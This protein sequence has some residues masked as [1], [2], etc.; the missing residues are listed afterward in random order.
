MLTNHTHALY[1]QIKQDLILQIKEGKISIN[2]QLPT[3]LELMKQYNVSRITVSKALNE[4]KNEGIIIRYPGKGSFVSSCADIS[5]NT[6]S[7]ATDSIGL[8]E[9]ACLLPNIRDSFALSI[10]R[11]FQD[12]FPSS[13]YLCH[14]M[15]SCNSEKENQILQYCIDSGIDGLVLFPLDQ[16]F[17][18]NQL[19]SM[20]LH[21]YPFVFVDK[22]LSKLDTSY[23]ISDNHTGGEYCFK[24]LHE[25]GHKNIAFVS[26]SP[27]ETLTVNCRI[28]GIEDMIENLHLSP[29][30]LKVVE[31]INSSQPMEYYRDWVSDL[32]HNKKIT[33]IVTAQSAA[34]LYIYEIIT[35]L[36]LSVPE[37]ISLLTFDNPLAHYKPFEFFT[38]IDQDEYNMGLR[39][40]MMLRNMIEKKDMSIRKEIITPKLEIRKSTG[41]AN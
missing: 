37:D 17:Y 35:S 3:E 30:P 5:P 38:Y 8:R 14:I 7:N 20:K 40:G 11:G 23:V 25:L 9:I 32:I 22:Y 4:L 19:L 41:P 26:C 24:Y 36:G 34:C 16:P 2:E 28:K 39:A 18:S 29:S 27:L 12:A 13:G 6:I 33:A 15:E 21:N 31:T 1:Q 10:I